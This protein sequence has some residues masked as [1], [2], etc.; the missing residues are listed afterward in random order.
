[1]TDHIVYLANFVRA[2]RWGITVPARVRP[3]G[4]SG[5]EQALR[6]CR[7]YH[8]PAIRAGFEDLLRQQ[9]ADKTQLACLPQGEPEPV[10]NAGGA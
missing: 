10:D 4:W 1:M 6:S 3:A 5:C 2:S 8:P 9:G 7:R